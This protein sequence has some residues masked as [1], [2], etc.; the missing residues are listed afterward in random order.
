MLRTQPGGDS[1]SLKGQRS[2]V[3][4]TDTLIRSEKF[5]DTRDALTARSLTENSARSE[6]GRKFSDQFTAAAVG[7]S[8][9]GQAPSINGRD[10]KNFNNHWKALP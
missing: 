7:Q 10:S 8:I 4:A 3:H 2:R 6:D 9:L 1:Q 5:N